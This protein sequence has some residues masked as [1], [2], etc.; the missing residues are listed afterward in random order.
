MDKS[1]KTSVPLRAQ[2]WHGVLAGLSSAPITDAQ[3]AFTGFRT[4]SRDI[5]DRKQIEAELR[6]SA[7]AFDSREGMLIT[8][9]N[10]KI[11]RVNKAFTEITGYTAERSSASIPTCCARTATARPSSRRCA[12]VRRFGK[13]QAKSGTAAKTAR[14]IPSG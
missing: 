9:A 12:S 10:S 11:L 8:D 2:G 7:V 14:S 4:S 5:T 6:I 3:G 13:W 1:A